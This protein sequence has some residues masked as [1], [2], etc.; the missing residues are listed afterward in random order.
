MISEAIG[1][2]FLEEVAVVLGFEE[3][4]GFHRERRKIV[5]IQRVAGTVGVSE[6]W[7]LLGCGLMYIFLYPAD[8]RLLH[9]VTSGC[10]HVKGNHLRSCVVH[11]LKGCTWQP[12][13]Y[14]LHVRDI[15]LIYL[16][17]ND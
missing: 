8:P 1:Q 9:C 6:T 12:Y 10:C 13:L 15:C 4:E 2:G 14:S 7:T 17:L 16:L 11:K 3:W 5:V